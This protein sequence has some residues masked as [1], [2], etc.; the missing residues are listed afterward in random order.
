MITE[1]TL[2]LMQNEVSKAHQAS[3]AVGLTKN[4]QREYVGFLQDDIVNSDATIGDMLFEIGSTSKTF[5]S[6]LLAKLVNEGRIT[7]DDPISAY[8]PEYKKALTYKGK[9]VTFR[10][11][12]THTSG[13]PREDMKTIRKNIKED[14]KRKNNPYKD[15]SPADLHRFFSNFTLTKDVGKKW[16]YSNLGVGLLGNTLAEICDMSYENAIK[17]HILEPLGMNDTMITVKNDQMDRYVKGY[18]KKG[19]P[20]PPIEL[21]A[22]N[23]AGAFKSSIND[24][25][26]Y[27]EHQIGIRENSLQESISMTHENQHV[28]AVKGIEM[29]LGWM[30]E[31]NKWSDVPIIQHGGTTV[32]FHTYCGFMKKHKIGVVIFSTI[33][34]PFVRLLRM[35]TGLEDLVNVNI[36]NS[37]FKRHL[38]I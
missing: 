38:P 14:K 18:T 31:N 5:T 27:L 4:K 8:K 13:L 33:Q 25:L 2:T 28:K 11:L 15:F 24:M 35:V 34:I 36:A 19:E 12:A 20:V 1:N 7:L 23:G 3:I 16:A 17:T 10:H 22:I 32:G 37:I 26:T 9:D 6:L 30:I 29:G 21:P